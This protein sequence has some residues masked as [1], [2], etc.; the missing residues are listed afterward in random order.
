LKVN[1]SLAFDENLNNFVTSI[2]GSM[3]EGRLAITV[4]NINFSLAF[5]EKLNNSVIS[6]DS[7]K[8]ERGLTSLWTPKI[9]L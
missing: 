8:M 6:V 7:S 4:L 3:M 2:K 9:G 5:N 1:L